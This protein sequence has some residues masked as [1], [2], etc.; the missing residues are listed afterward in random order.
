MKSELVFLSKGFHANHPNP[1]YK[2][3]ERKSDRPYIV[4]LM[5]IESTMWALPF[6]SHIPHEHAFW[7]D[8]ENRC[9][10]DY[11]KAVVVDN[12]NYIDRTRKPYLRP[13]EF[14]AIR[15][16]EHNIY[17]GFLKYIKEY[18]KARQS[19]HP[20]YRTLLECSTLQYYE[21]AIFRYG[22]DRPTMHHTIR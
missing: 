2:E 8:K 11:S 5:Q 22:T 13:K 21:D 6:R 16:Q 17:Q 18:K 1:P 12:P 19:N 10:I 3:I 4:L 20:R 7:T 14:E 9:G 15:G